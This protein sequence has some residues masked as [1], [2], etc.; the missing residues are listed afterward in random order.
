MV[1]MA[2]GGGFNDR[3]FLTG[4][5]RNTPHFLARISQRTLTGRPP[6]CTR[7]WLKR[8]KEGQQLGKTP[9]W[10]DGGAL[11]HPDNMQTGSTLTG[12]SPIRWIQMWQSA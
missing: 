2:T 1:F 5:I 4:R 6:Q 3:N 10:G 8:P 12:T 11:T 9:H 7:V